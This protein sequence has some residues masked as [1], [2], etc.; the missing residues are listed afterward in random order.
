MT[1]GFQKRLSFGE[2]KKSFTGKLIFPDMDTDME[3][4]I[5]H[6]IQD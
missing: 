2:K 3:L 1:M 5:Q 4:P 6:Y